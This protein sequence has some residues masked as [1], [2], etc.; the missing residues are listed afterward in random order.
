MILAIVVGESDNT[1]CFNF[2][3]ENI[4]VIPG[5]YNVVISKK[6]LAKFSSTNYDLTYYIEN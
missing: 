4:K 1:F 3:V 5:T 2:K 6:L